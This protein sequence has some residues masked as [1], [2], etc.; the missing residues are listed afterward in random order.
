MH[1]A[2]TRPPGEAHAIRSYAR[3]GSRLNARQ[4]GTW[5]GFAERYVM[6]PATQ[7]SMG[8]NLTAA[9]DRAAPLAVEIGSGVGE[10]LT[11]LAAD[12]P[13][14]NVVGFEV[15]RPG[16][17]ECLQRLARLAVPN[18]RLSTM[19]AVWS[20]EHS[21]APRSISELWTFFPDPWPKP[22]HR[23]RRL[24]NARFAELVASRLAADGVW[25][26][27]TDWPDYAEQMQDVLDAEPLLTGGVTERYADRPLTR[28]ERRGIAAGRPITDLTYRLR[29][30]HES[31]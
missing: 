23:K 28:F 13:D 7:S 30:P 18:V 22:R 26:L 29:R 16:I 21:V 2:A 20:L 27:A 9:F 24:V 3:R 11:R 25:R 15:W 1:A 10:A 5:D 4:Q 12:R 17:A 6:S 19:D 31:W 8:F 14:W